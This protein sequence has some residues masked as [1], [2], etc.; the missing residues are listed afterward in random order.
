M[1]WLQRTLQ[2]VPGALDWLE[3]AG[4]FASYGPL[5]ES[6]RL[7]ERSDFVALASDW[8]CIAG[9]LEAAM[10]ETAK[11]FDLDDRGPDT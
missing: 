11:Q 10:S 7:Y 5:P 4:S 3:G 8:Q 2:R 1:G 6:R 9:D